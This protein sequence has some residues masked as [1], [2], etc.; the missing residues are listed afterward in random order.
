MAYKIEQMGTSIIHFVFSFFTCTLL[1]P[2]VSNLLKLKWTMN[3]VIEKP[4][5]FSGD[6]L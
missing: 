6:V 5:T 2:L 3:S 1:L 4:I